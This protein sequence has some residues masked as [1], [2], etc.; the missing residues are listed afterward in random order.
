MK[1]YALS[2]LLFA[3]SSVSAASIPDFLDSADIN[4]AQFTCLE[5]VQTYNPAQQKYV[6]I[7]WD[8]TLSYLEA[9]AKALTNGAA[10]HCI[11]SDEAMY[12]STEGGKKMCIMDRRDMK[13]M[14]KNIY[15]VINNPDKA[16]KCFGAREDVDWIYSPGGDLEKNSPVAKWLKR[17]TFDTFFEQKVTNKDVRKLGKKFTQNFTKMVT[18]DDIQVPPAFPYDVSANALPNLWAA[19]GWYPMY[20]EES[21]RNEKNFMNI[22]GGYAYAEV[23]GHWGLL[24]IDE[25]NGQKVGAEVGMTVQSVGTVYPYHNHA[26]SEIYYNIRVPACLSQF[27]N[28][29]IR[30][31]SPLIKTVTEDDKVRRV[32][33]DASQLNE[34]L[35][36]LASTPTQDPLMYFHQNTIHAFDIDDSCEARP[37]EKAIVSVWARSNAHD[38]RNDYGTTLLCESASNPGTPALRGEVIQCDLTKTKW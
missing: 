8:E 30:E 1:K 36:W 6:D 15:Q 3:A 12:D 27:K 22:R 28:F 21:K 10:S 19:A 20:A 7:L 13:L 4:D 34:H 16:K 14:V 33:F 5:E 9:Y 31:D 29:A 17:A 11:N 23:F 32:Q 24:R 38:K 26:I 25:I 2:A 18:G 35:M 37:E